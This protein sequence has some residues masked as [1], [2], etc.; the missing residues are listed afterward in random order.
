MLF[1][2]FI[3]I[4]FFSFALV[5]EFLLVESDFSPFVLGDLRGNGHAVVFGLAQLHAQVGIALRQ[6]GGLH[7]LRGLQVQVPRLLA[8]PPSR[9]ITDSLQQVALETIPVPMQPIHIT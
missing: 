7:L 2:F 5:V 1:L 9:L 4:L 8:L 6:R 3:I